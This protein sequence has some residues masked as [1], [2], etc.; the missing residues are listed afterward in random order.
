MK[1][2]KFLLLFVVMASL[3][4][5]YLF[6]KQTTYY[7]I[8]TDAKNIVFVMDISGSMEGKNEGGLAGRATA[9]AANAGANVVE[10]TVGGRLG[11]LAG[12]QIRKQTTKLGSAKRELIPTIKGLTESTQFSVLIFED[13]VKS[14]RTAP[15]TAS[16]T[17]KNLAAVYIDAVQSGG[18]TSA[19]AA[20][21]QAFRIGGIDAIFFVT[22]GQPTDASAQE[23]LNL[24][25][26]KNRSKKV[27]INC[28]GIGDDQDEQFLR[29]LAAANNGQYFKK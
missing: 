4:G 1:M 24:A 6:K 19:K 12:S 8:S 26:S 20:L 29:Q 7:G 18:G 21:E 16:T 25:A 2:R 28:I 14:W 11:N 27:V 22:D 5:C 17:N 3:P 13:K 15:V 23:I 10:R 9:A